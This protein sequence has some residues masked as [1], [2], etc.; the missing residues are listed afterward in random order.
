MRPSGFFLRFFLPVF[1][2]LCAGAAGAAQVDRVE[3]ERKGGRFH[4][5]MHTRLSVPPQA[6][7]ATFSRFE[8]LP[9]INP[10]VRRASI[11]GHNGEATRVESRLKVCLAFFCPKFRMTQDMLGGAEGEAF[12]LAATVV[13]EL[14]DYRYGVGT[15]TFAPCEDGTC[16][17]FVAELEPK[18]WIPPLIGTWLMRRE[19]RAQAKATSE[20]IERLARQAMEADAPASEND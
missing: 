11:I 14:S 8:D 20:G 15:W 5:E 6:A 18:F 19:L 9:R 2:A 3:V 7:Y 1:V 4:V 17:S 10:S 12:T 16:L 13:P